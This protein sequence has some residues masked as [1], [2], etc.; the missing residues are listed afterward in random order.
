M[1]HALVYY[2]LS[3]SLKI[4]FRFYLYLVASLEFLKTL[5]DLEED[6]H[7]QSV[8]FDV[9]LNHFRLWKTFDLHKC[10]VET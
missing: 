7:K 10:Y 8:R 2:K 9:S 4:R 6:G 1:N 3:P 5:E